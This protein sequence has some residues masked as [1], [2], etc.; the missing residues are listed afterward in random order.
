MRRAVLSA[1]SVA[2]LIAGAV[3]ASALTVSGKLYEDTAT[4]NCGSVQC[5]V[6]FSVAPEIT[7]GKLIRIT[8][9]GCIFIANNTVE[10]V[11]FYVTDNG[12]NPRRYHYLT[13]PFRSGTFTYSFPIDYT[14]TGG[15]PRQ[16]Y[17]TFITASPNSQLTVTCTITGTIETP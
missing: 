12:F 9:L 7:A 6:V 16:P 17:M 8:D 13:A 4:G 3:P 11:T 1:L 10:R 5:N 15:P 2:A 14:F